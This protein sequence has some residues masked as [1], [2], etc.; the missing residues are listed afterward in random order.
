MALTA[1]E[2]TA[3]G[4]RAWGQGRGGGS[5]SKSNPARESDTHPMEQFQPANQQDLLQAYYF[6]RV[7]QSKILYYFVQRQQPDTRARHPNM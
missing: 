6:V 3:G 2:D 7:L 4:Q 1:G 5:I